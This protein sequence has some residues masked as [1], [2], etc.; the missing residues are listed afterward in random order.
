MKLIKSDKKSPLFF[1]P[2]IPAALML[3]TIV[4]PMSWTNPGKPTL[5]LSSRHVSSPLL[6]SG[7]YYETTAGRTELP[8]QLKAKAGDATLEWLMKTKDNRSAAIAVIPEGE[9]F[10]VRFGAQPSAGIV[11]WGFFID[12]P[13]DE[14][15][16]G[17]MERVVDGPQQESWAP[18]CT[19]AMN[20][21][22][23]KVE[24]LVKPTTSVY[25]PF[26]LS[27][28]G[29]G[30]FVKTDWPGVY[31]FAAT[32]PGKIAIE[33]EGPSLELKVYT[34]AQPAAIIQAH[35]L[36]A[37]PPFLPPKW[38]FTPWRWRDEH[39]HR[40]TY[41][42][43]T[44]VTGPFNSEMMEDVLMMRA[45][46]IPCGVYWID[47]PWGPG[48][49]GYDDFEI[50][51]KRLPNFARSVQWLKDHNMRMVLWIASFFQGQME[52][53]AHEK[54]YTL[55]GQK[56]SIQ[57]YPL[58]DFSNPEAKAY[59]QSGIEKLLQL[60]VAGF[61]LDRGEEQI[62]D[63]GPFKRFDGKSI[64]ENRNPYVAMFAKAVAEVVRKHRGDDFVAMPRGAYTGSS[65]H[66]VF[67]G[68][69][70]GGTQWGLRASIIAVQR[71]AVMGYPNWGSDTCGYN[72]QTLDP[73]MCARWLAFSCFTPIMEVGPTRNV[74][75][76]NLPREPKYDADLIAVWRLYARLHNR[77]ADY[78][79]AQAQEATRT[80]LPIVRPLFLADP[81]A[82]AA[83]SNWW[84]YLYGPDLLVSPVWEK[85]KRIQEVYLPA[86]F[87]WRSAWQPDK[88]YKGGRTIKVKADLHQMP[89]F[90]REGSG[91]DLGDLN[92][93]WQESV[94]IAAQKP[95]LKELESEVKAWFNK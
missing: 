30:L 51:P 70:I 20:L 33:F 14:Y 56:P 37:G 86:G 68:G 93:E 45:Y 83:W 64:R 88:V 28:R 61:K 8:V 60:G 44:P 19:E 92:K 47:R 9:H 91:M 69:D 22:G 94:T 78:S 32:D 10:T 66:A 23:Q 42:D 36:D 43:G 72:E 5:S 15:I 18:G 12:S 27:S 34:A 81:K 4:Q 1:W 35:A 59:W 52:K 6:F 49:I 73:D 16:T 79:H 3:L 87:T 31:D 63:G 2:A 67:W 95:D 85:D 62:P 71:A 77:L 82:P 46:G 74:A 89:I 39:T 76:W 90:I 17:L 7:F 13:Q 75:F 25:A 50:D 48:R 11:K 84:T 40:S 58:V 54:G 29:Y 80:G 41:Y 24:M 57:N 38:A 21:R 55:A 65:P 53:V 26:Y